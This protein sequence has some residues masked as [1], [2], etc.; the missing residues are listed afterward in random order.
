MSEY[1]KS[2]PKYWCKHCKTFVRD[3]KLEKTNHEATAKHQGNIKRFLRDLHRGHER[4]ERD[5]DR[6]KSEVERLNGVVSGTASAART[7]GPPS[8]HSTASMYP[9]IREPTPAER[10]A[11]L[12]KL[13]E[14]GVAV[15]ENY[16]REVAMAGDWQTVAERPVWSHVKKEDVLEDFKDFKPDSALN[17]GVRK[18]KFDGQEEEEAAGATVIRKGWGATTRHYPGSV[19]DANHDL[20]SLLDIKPVRHLGT[21]DK[22][23]ESPTQPDAGPAKS[24]MQVSSV[25]KEDS[26]EDVDLNNVPTQVEVADSVVKEEDNSI[27]IQPTV[28]FKKRKAKSTAA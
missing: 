11:Q 22:S 21:Q 3:T 1:W 2:T 15:P 17:V 12:A 7:G 16:R 5:K 19:P 6:A 26:R 27:Q 10:K 9:G 28:V 8:A 20:D 13:A 25:K 14:L 18:R 23:E 4:E 24:T